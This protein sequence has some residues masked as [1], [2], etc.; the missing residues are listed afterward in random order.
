[1][2]WWLTL[3][4]VGGAL[5]APGA[6]AQTDPVS[7]SIGRFAELIEEGTVQVS[8]TVTCPSGAAAL[9]SFVYVTDNGSSSQFASF[10]PICDG[11]AHTFVVAVAAGPGR[12]FR[13]GPAQASGYVLLNSGASTSPSRRVIIR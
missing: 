2:R 10:S 12:T 8:V 6:Q 4:V 5:T 11:S 9:E 1:M 13:R 3:A 7:A